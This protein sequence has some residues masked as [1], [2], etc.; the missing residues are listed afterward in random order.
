[1]PP[2]ELC[3]DKEL[4]VIYCYLLLKDIGFIAVHLCLNLIQA[5]FESTYLIEI[6]YSQTSTV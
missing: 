5:F 6:G 4:L 3:W 2:Y 1:M